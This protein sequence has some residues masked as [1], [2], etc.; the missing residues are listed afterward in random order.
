ME[1]R[2]VLLTLE[3]AL[4]ASGKLGPSDPLPARPGVWVR[5]S[6]R[7]EVDTL[8]TLLL[9]SQLAPGR[10]NVIRLD[11]HR[12]NGRVD[13]FVHGVAKTIGATAGLADEPLATGPGFPAMA[14]EFLRLA[15]EQDF[16]WRCA[17]PDGD[18]GTVPNWVARF[19]KPLR[20]YSRSSERGIPTAARIWGAEGDQGTPVIVDQVNLRTWVHHDG[21]VTEVLEEDPLDRIRTA[22]Q[23]IGKPQN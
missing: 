9:L 22:A 3:V 8:H 2:R 10:R 5:E 12:R 20:R 18:Y 19:E 13:R 6:E 15:G 16:N 7:C 23:I 14:V 17:W 4:E 21:I 11:C 1:A